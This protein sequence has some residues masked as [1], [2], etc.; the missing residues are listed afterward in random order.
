MIEG[1]CLPLLPRGEV[2]KVEDEEAGGAC[3]GCTSGRPREAMK[4]ANAENA[5][6]TWPWPRSDP[7]ALLEEDDDDDD[8]TV[9]VAVAGLS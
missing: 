8:L 3:C 4:E 9:A 6:P 7:D 2:T 5:W 1:V